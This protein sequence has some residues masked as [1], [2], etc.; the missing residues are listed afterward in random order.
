MALA[1]AR[2][3]DPSGLPEPLADA[4]RR[5]ARA[6][7]AHPELLSGA[8][9]DTQDITSALV[10]RKRNVLIAKSGAE[11]LYTVGIAPGILGERGVGLAVRAEDGSNVHRSCYLATIEALCQLG[12]VDEADVSHLD[13]FL[14]RA[15]RNIHGAIVGEARVSFTLQR[16]DAFQDGQ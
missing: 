5:I 7:W 1:F 3:V 14:G 9:G 6:M 2:L 16:G 11:A 15:I 13:S 4:C 8:E 12:A 10:T